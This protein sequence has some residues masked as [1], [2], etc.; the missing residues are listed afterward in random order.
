MAF[1]NLNMPGKL[2]QAGA[3]QCLTKIIQNAPPEALREKMEDLC[4]GLLDVLNSSN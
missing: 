3:A 1:T 2:V 4:Q